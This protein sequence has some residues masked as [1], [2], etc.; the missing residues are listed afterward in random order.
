MKHFQYSALFQITFLSALLIGSEY[1]IWKVFNMSFSEHE[2]FAIGYITILCVWW[3]IYFVSP[4]TKLPTLRI[5][6]REHSDIRGENEGN[7]EGSKSILEKSHSQSTTIALFIAV[8]SMFLNIVLSEDASLTDFQ[9]TIKQFIVGLAFLAILLFVFA[10]DLLDS[11]SNP[12]R[13]NDIEKK[14]MFYRDIGNF[15]PN[16]GI[17]YAYLGYSLFTIILIT[18][19]SFF[20]IKLTGYFLAVFVYLSYPIFYGYRMETEDEAKHWE[21]EELRLIYDEHSGY[22]GTLAAIFIF[23][24]ASITI[25]VFS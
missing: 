24:V 14:L 3:I 22:R 7:L 25:Y 23:I 17:S 9:E 1:F 11:V 6:L 8:M 5:Y 16:G 10:I 13:E 21:R 15:W 2:H 20:Y 12:F 19:L 18:I 4:K